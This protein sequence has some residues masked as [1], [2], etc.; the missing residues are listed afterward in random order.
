MDLRHD[1][2]YIECPQCGSMLFTEQRWITVAKSDSE[3][4]SPLSPAFAT[5]SVLAL[6]C[7][8][9]GRNYYSGAAVVK[10]ADDA[11]AN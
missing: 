11:G 1:I 8:E 7:V 9:C 3:S 6:V 5:D 2:M 10:G 4:L